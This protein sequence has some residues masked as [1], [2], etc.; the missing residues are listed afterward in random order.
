MRGVSDVSASMRK[1]CVRVWKA[2]NA[3]RG[4]ALLVADDGPKL[5]DRASLVAVDV[6]PVR[7]VA[8][9]LIHQFELPVFP[10]PPHTLDD[11][12]PLPKGDTESE[13]LSLFAPSEFDALGESQFDEV[14]RLVREE[15]RREEGVDP[16]R[17][18]VPAS[19]EGERD[20]G[21]ERA[22]VG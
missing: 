3:E 1:G 19:G 20:G 5:V 13:A 14:V 11:D 22:R 21:G 4:R 16:L 10:H 17:D 8:S 18:G 6:Y 2:D 7:T 15:V 12:A 9:V